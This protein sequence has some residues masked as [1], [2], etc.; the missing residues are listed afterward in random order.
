MRRRNAERQVLSITNTNKAWVVEE[1]GR[2]L[3]EWR[4]WLEFAKSLGDSPDYDPKTCA[5]AMK[6]G[7]E[8]RRRHEVLREKTLVF[9]VNNFEGYDFAFY[10]WPSHPHEDNLSRLRDIVPGWIHRLEMLSAAVPYA[11]VPESYWKQKGK[12]LIDQITA[13]P[14]KAVEIATSFLRSP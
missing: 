9:I 3:D 2:L 11:R 10:N 4:A 8:N 5:E 13:R 7:R 1:L 6:D 12:Q 14:D